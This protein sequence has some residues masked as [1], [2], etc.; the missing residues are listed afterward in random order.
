MS[1]VPMNRPVGFFKISSYGMRN[2]QRLHICTSLTAALNSRSTQSETNKKEEFSVE[3]QKLS[4]PQSKTSP[5]N[6]HFNR[7]QPFDQ[8]IIQEDRIEFGQFVAREALLDEEFWEFTALKRRCRKQQKHK[9]T[10]VV[11]VKKED[12]NVKCTILKSVVG[13]LDLSIRYLLPGETFPG[14]MVKAPLFCSIDR[15][16]QNRYSYIANL[17]VSK[18]ARRQGIAMNMLYFAVKLAKSNGAQQVFVH[19]HRKNRPAQELYQKMGF[20]VFRWWSKW[21]PLNYRKSKLT[22]FALNYKTLFGRSLFPLIV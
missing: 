20:E 13:T 17:C 2:C 3:N 21:Q 4:I 9:C 10:C 7:L 1:I 19:V 11:T 22:C 5:L 14:E 18:S 12:K 15:T 16:G 6:L 8:E